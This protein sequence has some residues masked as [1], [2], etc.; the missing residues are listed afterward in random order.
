M[1]K[2]KRFQFKKQTFALPYTLISI[3]FV[4]VPLLILMYYAFTNKDTGA[5]TLENFSL[6]KES[7]MWKIMEISF[8]MALCTTLICFLLSYP[9]AMAVCRIKSNKTF[10]IVMLFILPMWINSLLRI[11][12]VK[13]LFHNYLGLERGFLLSLIGMVYDFF[14]FMFLPIYTILSNMNNSYFEASTDLGANPIRT[15][16]KVKLPLSVPGIVSGIL[17]VFMPCI[18]TFAINDLLGSS[19][20]ELF[21]N[22]IYFWFEYGWYNIGSALA[23]V[24]LLLIVVSVLISSLLNKIIEPRGKPNKKGETIWKAKNQK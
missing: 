14:P 5:F 6:F 20:Y 11:Y 16:L 15:F 9:L 19:Q 1:K 8:I 22:Q 3:V 12:S 21:G 10:I 2:R 4:V 18:S 24:M 13:L 17:M 7:S 23:V